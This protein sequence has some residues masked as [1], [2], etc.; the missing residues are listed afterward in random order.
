MFSFYRILIW[1]RSI[2]HESSIYTHIYYL[3][4]FYS[5]DNPKG[6]L[7]DIKNMQTRLIFQKIFIPKLKLKP[8]SSYKSHSTKHIPLQKIDSQWNFFFQFLRIS[9]IFSK[10]FRT[11]YIDT[12]FFHLII[13]WKIFKVTKSRST[14]F[15]QAFLV[16][17]LPHRKIQ[18]CPKKLDLPYTLHVK[19]N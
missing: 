19:L 2:F 9:S 12:C 6:T 7:L 14:Q 16:S 11:K 1:K 17:Q 10:F 15:F 5:C 4:H 8:K 13:K 18:R 3:K